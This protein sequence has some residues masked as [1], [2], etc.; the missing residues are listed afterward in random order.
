MYWWLLL[1]YKTSNHLILLHLE[2][3]FNIL[4]ERQKLL[5][6]IMTLFCRI[7]STGCLGLYYVIRLLFSM[8]GIPILSI[9]LKYKQEVSTP[10]ICSFN[11]IQGRKERK[12]NTRVTEWPKQRPRYDSFYEHINTASISLMAAYRRNLCVHIFWYKGSIR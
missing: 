5:P 4:T 7:V 2:P 12:G 8:G 1:K 9:I 3:H 11:L 10:M 6:F